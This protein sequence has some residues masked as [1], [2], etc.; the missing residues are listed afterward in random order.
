[1]IPRS[2]DAVSPDDNLD[3]VISTVLVGIENPDTAEAID[4]T[5]AVDACDA[6]GDVI[7]GKILLDSSV[8]VFRYEDEDAAFDDFND[9]LHF[10]FDDDL[11]LADLLSLCNEDDFDVSFVDFDII[12]ALGLFIGT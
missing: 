2:R 10:N 1:M 12:V 5:N 6:F 9:D 11:F 3:A 4:D 7:F 8:D